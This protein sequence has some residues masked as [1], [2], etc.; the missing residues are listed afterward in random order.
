V[1]AADA[2]RVHQHGFLQSVAVL[3][4]EEM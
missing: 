1:V 2:G 4:F 3:A